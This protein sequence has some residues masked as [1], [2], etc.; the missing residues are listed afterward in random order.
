MPPHAP[1]AVNVTV[2]GNGYQRPGLLKRLAGGL[3]TYWFL[4]ASLRIIFSGVPVWI[5]TVM[6]AILG[7]FG[8]KVTPPENA[9]NVLHNAGVVIQDT[10]RDGKEAAEKLAAKIREEAAERER[11]MEERWKAMTDKAR[12]VKEKVGDKISDVKES[13]SDKIGEAKLAASIAALAK[14]VVPKP[15]IPSFSLKPDPHVGMRQMANGMWISEESSDDARR[16][17]EAWEKRK[18]EKEGLSPQQIEEAEEAQRQRMFKAEQDIQ[19]SRS[20]LMNGN[21]S[22]YGYTPPMTES[23]KSQPTVQDIMA[24]MEREGR[25]RYSSGSAPTTPNT[26]AGH[27]VKYP[28]GSLWWAPAGGGQL[29]PYDPTT[30]KPVR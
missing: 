29:V 12:D 15:S 6:A 25:A 24:R 26:P 19:R 27:V 9:G 10:I 16:R 7:I 3:L 21:T 30:G 4:Q 8:W 28:N 17:V 11:K 22:G 23:Q 14:A 18:M 1:Q 20:F 5:F 2:S 13:V